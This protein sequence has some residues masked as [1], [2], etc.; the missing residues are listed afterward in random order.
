METYEHTIIVKNED[1]D[2]LNHVN[3]VRYVQWINDIAKA[4]WNEKATSS[5]LKQYYWVVLEH[6]IKYK[7]PAVLGDT[8]LLKTYVT[9]AEGVTSTRIVEILNKD[10]GKLI[11][12]AESNWCLIS[13]DTNRPTRIPQD[14]SRLFN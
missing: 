14:L 5:M 2:E 3:N 11:V 9:K 13:R 4:H 7:N 12:K 1:L 8:I 6:N 10:N